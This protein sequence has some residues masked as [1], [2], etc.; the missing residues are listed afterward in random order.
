ME[1]QK[2]SQA[3]TTKLPAKVSPVKAMISWLVEAD[4]EYRVAQ[5]MVNE[6]HDKI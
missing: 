4:R 5:A 2:K 1:R 6:K 3:D